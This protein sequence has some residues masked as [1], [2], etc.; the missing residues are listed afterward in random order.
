MPATTCTAAACRS[1]AAAPAI[2]P[3]RGWPAG[4][5]AGPGAAAGATKASGAAAEEDA[6]AIINWPM[7]LRYSASSSSAP[8]SVM[9]AAC[10]SVDATMP[11]QSRLANCGRYGALR[12]IAW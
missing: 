8:S 10:A 4:A 2:N 11:G 3:A 1:D 12:S 7:R 6:A 5:C 9:T